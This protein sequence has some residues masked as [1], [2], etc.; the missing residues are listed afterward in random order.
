VQQQDGLA[1]K[2]RKW[3]FSVYYEYQLKVTLNLHAEG[4]RELVY[5]NA[6]Q[7]QQ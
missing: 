5:S 3:Q 1:L 2:F 4:L 6:V 7:L